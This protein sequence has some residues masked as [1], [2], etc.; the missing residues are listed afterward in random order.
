MVTL[1][2][3]QQ[4][5]LTTLFALF[6]SQASAIFIQPDWFDPTQPGVGTNRYSYSFNDPINLIDPNG[7]EAY[8]PSEY[9]SSSEGNRLEHEIEQANDYFNDPNVPLEDRVEYAKYLINR[10]NIYNLNQ[11]AWD[12]QAIGLCSLAESMHKLQNTPAAAKN[13]PAAATGA[14]PLAT[15]GVATVRV[16]KSTRPVA[17][18]PKSMARRGNPNHAP[19][20]GNI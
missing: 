19:P 9:P 17:A 3:L 18:V 16:P 12:N 5:I 10:V 8:D 2:D 14:E 6:A 1:R 15:V 11:P 7:N 4:L 13:A 20:Q